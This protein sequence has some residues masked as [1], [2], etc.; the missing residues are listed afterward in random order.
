MNDL[1]VWN[2]NNSEVRTV[3]VND[4]TWWVLADVCKVLE[5]S[6]PHK[7]ADRLDVDERNQIPLTD[8]LG[9]EQTLI[10]SMKADFTVYL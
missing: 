1:T 7:V 4:E 2:F 9:R 5:L 8:S 10:S 6:S 3:T